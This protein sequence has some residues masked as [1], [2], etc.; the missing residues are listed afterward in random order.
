MAGVPESQAVKLE[1]CNY[2]EPVAAALAV[3]MGSDVSFIE[4]EIHA[5]QAQVWR[6]SYHNETLGYAVTRMEPD[7]YVI[8]CYAGSDVQEYAHFVR[9][10][11]ERSKIPYA[12]FH[13]Q[14]P[15]LIRLLASLNPEPLEY[16]LR[17]RCYGR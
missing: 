9:R 10:V 13:T 6:F 11:C 7:C 4:A 3:A 17:V 16:V 1:L 2:S 14:R 15:G 5:E 8:V 12:R